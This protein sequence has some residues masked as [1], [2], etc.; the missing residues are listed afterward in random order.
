MAGTHL[1]VMMGGVAAAIEFI[2]PPPT[3]N[4]QSS[5]DRRPDNVLL[6]ELQRLWKSAITSS[7]VMVIGHSNG[8]LALS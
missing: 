6:E 5:S 7:K 3:P 1:K 2:R 8:G 4:P